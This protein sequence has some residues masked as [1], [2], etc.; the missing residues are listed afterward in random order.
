MGPCFGGGL[1]GR[2]SG[3]S[4]PDGNG[5]QGAWTGRV[6]G[7][8]RLVTTQQ[9][10]RSEAEAGMGWRK[11]RCQGWSQ[12]GRPNG[13]RLAPEVSLQ[14]FPLDGTLQ[15]SDGN[16]WTAQQSHPKNGP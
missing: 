4:A 8:S 3:R 12:T 15:G 6:D 10:E 14:V 7:S 11:Q 1:R 13:G 2:F 5:P 16:H 9:K